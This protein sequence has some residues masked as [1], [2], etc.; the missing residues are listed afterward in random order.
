M[1]A[2]G[3]AVQ[4]P[5][6]APR[7]L[8]DSDLIQAIL[9]GGANVEAL[10]MR[11]VRER[12]GE[13][14]A[15]IVDGSVADAMVAAG[16]ATPVDGS[17]A[18]VAPMNSD[19]RAAWAQWLS[20]WLRLSTLIT[21]R[22]PQGSWDDPTGLPAWP[23]VRSHTAHRIATARMRREPVHVAVLRVEDTD[24]WNRRAQVLINDA[25]QARV[26][27]ELDQHVA[28]GDELSRLEDGAFILVTSRDDAS[29]ALAQA[30]R[31]VIAQLPGDG[32]RSLVVYLGVATAPWD[33]TCPQALLEAAL[34][35]AAEQRS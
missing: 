9:D 24:L 12:T 8:G 22:A 7:H 28:P 20:R 5:T 25:F 29:P 3:E 1:P 4:P 33:A 6:G 21:M 35:R 10:L 2:L 14:L 16:T 26:A 31:N 17:R 15:R 18:L 34:R 32:P 30:L 27:A 13:P 23:R 19:V 11:V